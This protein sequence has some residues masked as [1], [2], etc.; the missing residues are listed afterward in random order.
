MNKKSLTT[1]PCCQS[2][3]I[4]SGERSTLQRNVDLTN[5]DTKALSYETKYLGRDNSLAKSDTKYSVWEIS[6]A[7]NIDILEGTSTKGP[8]VN[9]ITMENTRKNYTILD[10]VLQHEE[11]GFLRLLENRTLRQTPLLKMVDQI[12]SEIIGT[13]DT[14]GPPKDNSD[15]FRDAQLAVVKTTRYNMQCRNNRG[16]KSMIFLPWNSIGTIWPWC[17]NIPR[18]FWRAWH[19]L[20][21]ERHWFFF[22]ISFPCTFDFRLPPP[23]IW[24]SPQ[25]LASRKRMAW[26]PSRSAYSRCRQYLKP[27]VQMLL[28]KLDIITQN[29]H[30]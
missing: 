17:R 16:P 22:S 18:I 23:K 20:Q 21:R 28:W 25:R 2:L 8:R 11:D 13:I 27:M 14:Y 24:I 12:S 30:S 26:S 10:T 7:I 29:H 5:S 4:T 1:W 3:K 15:I 9:M 6:I 19:Q